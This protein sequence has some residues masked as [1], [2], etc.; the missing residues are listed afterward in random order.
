[1]NNEYFVVKDFDGFVNSARAIVFNHFGSSKNN[2][3]DESDLLMTIDPKDEKELDNILS[4]E[5]SC[6]IVKEFLKKQTNQKTHK[7]RYLV[8]DE[9]F[10]QIIESLN[11]RMTS[12]ILNDL[13]KKGLVETGYDSESN[14]F[15]FWVKDE[16]KTIEEEK[17]E[18]D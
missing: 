3:D 11:D 6:V 1:M 10:L 18:T 7:I 2:A 15:I 13:V 16:N 17:P 5:E 12:N 8:S 4:V 9:I 14:D